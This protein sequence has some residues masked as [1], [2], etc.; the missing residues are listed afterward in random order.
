MPPNRRLLKNKFTATA[1]K[2]AKTRFFCMDEARFGLK[3]WFHRRWCPRGERPPWIAGGKYKWLW[4]YAAVEPA[5]GESFCLYM[6]NMKGSC[7]QVFLEQLRKVYPGDDIK[8]VLDGAPSHRSGDVNWPE[9]V[10]PMPLPPYSPEL[11]P[12]ERWF[13]ELRKPLSNR[14]FKTTNAIG[15]ALREALRPYWQQPEKLAQLTG[16]D[17]WV[18]GTGNITTSS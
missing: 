12:V 5:T 2:H 17:W 18:E 13:E 3:V 4:L 1:K 7:L 8:L 6:P 15:D 10:E 9:A 14:I 16:Y 11:N